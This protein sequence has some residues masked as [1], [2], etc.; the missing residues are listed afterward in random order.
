MNRRDMLNLGSTGSLAA[1]ASSLPAAAQSAVAGRTGE[2]AVPRREVFELV[3]PGPASGNP[4]VDV[5]LTGVFRL[6]Q[7]SVT[8]D[9]FYDGGGID[10]WNMTIR[11]VPGT[12]SGTVTLKLTGRP[13]QAV[14]F[15]RVL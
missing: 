5:Q 3:L 14:R 2:A 8:V 15:R 13:F 6:G 9:G 7:R 1:L 11:A 10:P 12:L 4:F